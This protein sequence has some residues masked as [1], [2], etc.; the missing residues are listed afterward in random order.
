MTFNYLTIDLQAPASKFY[1]G[2]KASKIT[3]YPVDTGRKLCTFNLRPVS[4]GYLQLSKTNI[5]KCATIKKQVA[6][7]GLEST[8]T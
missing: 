3:S 6:A 8:T 5:R 4:T 2:L 7:T 1:N